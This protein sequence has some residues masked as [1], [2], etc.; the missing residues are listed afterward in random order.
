MAKLL[1][2]LTLATLSMGSPHEYQASSKQ[3]SVQCRTEYITLWDTKYKE[4]E[5]QQC[6]TEYEKACKTEYE[7][8]C[9]TTFKKE[10][11]TI[12]EKQCQTVY[13]YVCLE[14]YRTEYEPYTETGQSGWSGQGWRGSE[15][16]D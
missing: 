6:T 13:K 11:H 4:T 8:V 9:K 7:R 10:C 3:V 1:A 16:Q 2:V 5:T 14:Q 12:Y 15:R